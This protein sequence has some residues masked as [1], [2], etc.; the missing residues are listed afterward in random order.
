MKAIIRFCSELYRLRVRRN[1]VLEI[2]SQLFADLNSTTYPNFINL[3]SGKIQNTLT[4]E[5][6]RIV[7]AYTAYFKGI[8]FIILSLVYILLSLLISFQF[9]LI[10]LIMSIAS[11]FLINRFYRLTKVN[12]MS[13]TQ[14]LN[15]LQGLIIQYVN[16][17]QYLKSTSRLKQYLHHLIDQIKVIEKFSFNI[18]IYDSTLVSL[19]EPI[20]IVIIC[21]S[22]VVQVNFFE[23]GIESIL[24]VLAF[25]YRA[26]TTIIQF[27][28]QINSFLGFS[29]SMENLRTFQENI[30]SSET[31]IQDNIKSQFDHQLE[32]RNVELILNEKIVFESIDFSISKNQSY[33]FFGQSGAG[34]TSIINLITRLYK[35][36][37]GIIKMDGIDINSL[38]LDQYR[39]M[40]GY[41]TQDPILFEDSL[42]NNIS[43][44]DTKNESSIAKV[45]DACRKAS[46]GLFLDNLENGHDN[47]VSS[48]KVSGGERQRIAIARELYRDVQIL[49]LDEPTSAL[50]KKT[51][52]EIFKTITE[53]ATYV[54][55]IIVSH[56]GEVI[57]YVD[58][59]FVLNN[60][61]LKSLK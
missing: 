22:I 34:K 32:F 14:S 58:H 57:N 17:Y 3:E 43:F 1:F 10:V 31:Y 4:G 53:I 60:K 61:G 2:R 8:E 25:L 29:G 12:S 7:K 21:F 56:N 6:A 59:A 41:V 15:K 52:D 40:I 28:S 35:P 49:L 16:N 13:L 11:N 9:T 47:Q 38:G 27:Q 19:R 30:Q 36:S 42:F 54:T 37:N 44:W 24:L 48:S 33:A 23:A 55:V 5:I 50:D 26:T 20:L 46:L 45:R 51:E 39:N 18:G